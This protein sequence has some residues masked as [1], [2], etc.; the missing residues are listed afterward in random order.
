MSEVIEILAIGISIVRL[1][2]DY[3]SPPPQ[4]LTQGTKQITDVDGLEVLE[5]IAGEHRIH[6]VVF[7]EVEVGQ[8]GD[9]SLHSFRRESD[10]TVPGVDCD[11]PS[12]LYVVDEVAVTSAKL[13]DRRLRNDLALQAKVDESAPKCLSTRIEGHSGVVV[14][15]NH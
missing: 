10:E 7:E 9:P 3:L 1:D 13:H 5:E 12:T 14:V 15:V 6:A 8:V 2:Q 4:L 11:P